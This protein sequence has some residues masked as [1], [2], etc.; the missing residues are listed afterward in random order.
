MH[1]TVVA[2]REQD[3]V[4]D[5]KESKITKIVRHFNKEA[6][7]FANWEEDTETTGQDCMLADFK[8]WRVSN[9]VKE[10]EEMEEL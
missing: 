4:H 7:V 1:K 5:V 3:A 6:S 2:P 10:E 9:F 8:Y